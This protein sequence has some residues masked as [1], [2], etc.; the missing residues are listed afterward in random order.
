M[1]RNVMTASTTRYFYTDPLAQAWMAQHF[2]MKFQALF[3]NVYD[4]RDYDTVG[5]ILRYYGKLYIHPDSLPLLEPSI[6][7]AFELE[8]QYLGE[9]EKH[10]VRSLY[11]VTGKNSKGVT[12]NIASIDG[13]MN[14]HDPINRL[15]EKRYFTDPTKRISVIRR[16]GLPFHWP[17]Q[18]PAP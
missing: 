11:Y 8:E 1:E 6:G 15:L 4:N 13:T 2:G 18:E 10:S 9:E 16:D 7:D 14:P 5:E 12:V 3:D 17:Q